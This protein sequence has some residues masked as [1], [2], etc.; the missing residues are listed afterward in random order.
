MQPI[1]DFKPAA[2]VGRTQLDAHK[3]LTLL[4]D[5]RKHE[6]TGALNPMDEQAR[7]QKMLSFVNESILKLDDNSLLMTRIGAYVVMFS[8]I[9]SRIRAMYRQRHAMI[10]DLPAPLPTADD[11]EDDTVT[12]NGRVE[13]IDLKRAAMILRRYEDIDEDSMTEIN[14]FIDIRNKM[15]H[16]ALY[17]FDA[18]RSDILPVLDKLYDHMVRLRA[19]LTTRL[20]NERRLYPSS[21]AVQ[22]AVRKRLSHIALHSDVT[23]GDIFTRVGGSQVLHVPI[24]ANQPLYL[25][26][27]PSKQ[28]NSRSPDIVQVQVTDEL[29]QTDLLR[30]IIAAPIQYVVFQKQ[31]GS[32]VQAV[33]RVGEGIIVSAE[34]D[35]HGQYKLLNVQLCS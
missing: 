24:L 7:K 34:F 12:V 19:R 1:R 20:T 11:D 26:A 25:V 17:R 35:T 30:D 6:L 29:W 22:A 28:T 4:S 14:L 16:Q 31:T 33:R 27:K 5:T 8:Q 32:H 18:F 9:E 10:Y 3:R 13:T 15:I 2:Q 21:D 23:R